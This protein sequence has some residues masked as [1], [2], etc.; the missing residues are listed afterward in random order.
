MREVRTVDR[1][2]SVALGESQPSRLHGFQ[3]AVGGSE[4]HAYGAGERAHAPAGLLDP[5]PAKE[6]PARAAG[7]Q[8][9]EHD[10]SLS[11]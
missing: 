8:I 7:H 9:I 1:S 2:D 4:T 11:D 5:E 10:G 6:L 3:L